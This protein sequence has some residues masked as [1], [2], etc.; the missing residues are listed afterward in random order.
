VD[1][2]GSAP[3]HFA[4]RRPRDMA[5]IVARLPLLLRR[6]PGTIARVVSASDVAAVAERLGYRPP[7]GKNRADIRHNAVDAVATGMAAFPHLQSP[8]LSAL[9]DLVAIAVAHRSGRNGRMH[10]ETIYAPARDGEGRHVVVS[11]KPTAMLTRRE[12]GQVRDLMLRARLR[13]SADAGSHEPSHE[14]RVRRVRLARPSRD[15]IVLPANRR[16]APERAV[17]SRQNFAIDIVALPDG[18]WKAFGITQHERLAS[19]WRPEWERARLGGKLVMRLR[20]GD[21]IELDGPQGRIVLRVHRLAPSNGY[22]WVADIAEAGNLAARH[23]ATDDT[24]RFAYLSAQQLRR[25]HARAVRFT[26]DGVLVP[27]LS[28][29]AENS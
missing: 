25:R 13:Q 9:H 11:R 8:A 12:I 10:C 17:L 28:N 18:S 14:H 1:P 6:W 5:M 19:G 16:G 23:A 2:T 3:P 21:C 22:V 29:V 20:R 26:A 4:N 27:R 24:F 15:A 7:G